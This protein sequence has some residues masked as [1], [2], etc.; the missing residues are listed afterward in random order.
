MAGWEDLEQPKNKE[1]KDNQQIIDD[2]NKLVLRVFGSED[3]LKLL[4]W[5][6]AAYLDQSVA[7]PGSDSSHAYFREGQ[8]SVVR[9][10]FNR[11]AKAR[12]L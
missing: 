7:I 1:I 12:K 5:F 9:D 2:H 3:G 10:I 6:K 8:N 4:N 11:I